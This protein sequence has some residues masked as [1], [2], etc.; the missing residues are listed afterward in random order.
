MIEKETAVFKAAE[1]ILSVFCM[2]Q[3]ATGVTIRGMQYE[4]EKGTLT[5]E[6][7]LGVSNHFIGC[8]AEIKVSEGK[9]LLIWD[10]GVSL[11][12]IKKL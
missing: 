1:G 6:F 10:A 9:L 7:P 2:G 12:E 8:P 3:P 5:A 11:P 4:L